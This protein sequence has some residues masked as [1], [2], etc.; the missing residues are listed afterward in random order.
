MASEVF[1][2][3]LL[4]TLKDAAS[5]G[6]DRF[7][8]KLRAAGKSGEK[9]H[10]DFEKI[11]KDLNRDL[12]IGGIGITGLT[13]LAKGVKIAADYQS[14]V[15]DLRATMASL[16]KQG[17]IN[18]QELTERMLKSEAVA[19]RL[20]N[21]LPGTTEDFVQMMQVLKQNGLDAE[22]ILNGAADAVA[23][24]AVANKDVPK[25]IAADFAQY[26]NLFKLKPEEFVPAADVF[27]RIF[28]SSG[29]T[30][31]ELVEAAKYFQ[32]RAGANL[33]IGGLKD[34]EQ[35]TR[36]FGLMGKEGMRGSMAG[37]MLTD[38][39]SEYNQHREKLKDLQKDTGIKLD[40]FDQKGQFVG[41]DEVFKQMEQFN[42]LSTEKRSQ[43][44][45]DIFG[46]RGM[47]AGNVFA[48]AG[49]AG[50]KE[51]NASQEQTISLT[52]KTEEISKTFN[53]QLE[54][55]TG[56]GK[57]LI[58]SFFEPV[59]GDLTSITSGLNTATGAVQEFT[60]AHP[61][62]AKYVVE[63]LAI[64]S[65][66]MVA[67]SGIKTLT[68]GVRIYRLASAFSKSEGLV[69][70]LNATNAAAPAATKNVAGFTSTVV[71]AK[72]KTAG[73]RKDLFSLNNVFKMVLLM[74]TIGFTWNQISEMR[75]TINDWQQTQRELDS[76]SKQSSVA[77][78][79][80]PAEQKNPKAE[81]EAMMRMLQAGSNELTMALDPSKRTWSDWYSR[82]IGSL[83]GK[84]TEYSLYKGKMTTSQ[85]MADP[86]LRAQ[87]QEMMKQPFKQQLVDNTFTDAYDRVASEIAAVKNLRERASS[88]ADPQVMSSFRRDVMPTM[89]LSQERSNFLDRLLQQAF[90]ESFAQSGQQL[91][92]TL[93]AVQ[94]PIAGL[95]ESLSSL[96]QPV[97]GTAE[98]FSGLPQPVATVN[99]SFTDL[100][101]PIDQTRQSMV[102]LYVAGNRLPGGFDNILNSA[103]SVSNSLLTVSETLAS[104][105]PPAP[106]SSTYIPGALS[107]PSNSSI[108][109]PLG[110][111]HAVG[112]FIHSDGVVRVHAGNMIT[113][114]K[115]TRG[116]KGFGELME[117]ARNANSRSVAAS[118]AKP[119]SINYSPQITFHGDATAESKEEF[120][121]MLRDHAGEIERIVAR[122]LKDAGVRA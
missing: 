74:E 118:D 70:M 101:P 98:I 52:Q 44:M 13:T 69:G 4:L 15:T 20:G 7:E 86:G 18:A 3:A 42:K 71:A 32:G 48:K 82:G 57:N 117:L 9:F 53:N 50:W 73:L 91:A 51:Y 10:N 6:L 102:D 97:A 36:L 80:L 72:G 27:S 62:V 113:P 11:R 83:M 112:G 59:L 17:A 43:W 24:L 84:N 34:A 41:M 122:K 99:Q 39:F 93:E 38:F 35:I 76:A 8:A 58:V 87:V 92:A 100:R 78:Q 81:A 5:G 89:G 106:P 110:P 88:L 60:K 2:L 54:A 55:L 121:Q 21:K 75:K 94:Q 30:A 33:G 109:D 119:V 19:I 46:L 114:A 61:Q 116:V 37:T 25:D 104:W 115:A 68:A 14:S 63:F 79:G 40:F 105:K 47:T 64:G 85:I 67:Y 108:F 65:A 56:T 66:V 23:N 26:G 107:T 90:P 96:Q 29:Q 111:G 12:A 22:T 49:T 45:E 31:G 28:T 16:D 95:A 1:Q 103:N 77:Y 120:R